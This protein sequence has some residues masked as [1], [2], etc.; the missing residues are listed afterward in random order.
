MSE[1]QRTAGQR[2]TTSSVRQLLIGLVCVFLVVGGVFAVQSI[3][4][5]QWEGRCVEDG[6]RV[7]RQSGGV[8]PYLA[9][10]SVIGY[11]CVGSSGSVI[12]SWP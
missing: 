8:E 10:G 3:R 5:V 12:S 2:P 11:T 4:R 6:G 9:P 1:V 7:A